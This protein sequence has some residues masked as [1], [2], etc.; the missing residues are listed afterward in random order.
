MVKCSLISTVRTGCVFDLD[1]GCSRDLLFGRRGS[2]NLPTS[3]RKSADVAGNYSL[4]KGPNKNSQIK[5]RHLTL[6]TYILTLER[7]SKSLTPNP[8][9]P[10]PQPSK[11][12]MSSRTPPG[13][14]IYKVRTWICPQ[15]RKKISRRSS[16]FELS[17][18]RARA[19][20]PTA[21]NTDVPTHDLIIGPSPS[22]KYD[23]MINLV[24]PK[25]LPFF[26]DVIK[27]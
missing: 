27:L 26:L 5:E 16:T 23:P 14:L 17:F 1:Q 9:R 6:S 22:Q 4:H 18:P 19:R 24:V 11:P 20:T 3:D 13:V 12:S 7:A 15:P 25:E 21:E 2:A 10:T 8:D